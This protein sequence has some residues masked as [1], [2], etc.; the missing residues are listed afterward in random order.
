[1]PEQVEIEL[2]DFC[3][4]CGISF[5][6]LERSEWPNTC[7]DCHSRMPRSRR[8]KRMASSANV[9]RI[10]GYGGDLYLAGNGIEQE[11]RKIKNKQL[12]QRAMEFAAQAKRLALEIEDWHR[13][14]VG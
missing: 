2:V 4:D 13:Q 14:N 5:G 11:G 6:I 1:M 12:R 9:D 3:E 8:A 10:G 7:V